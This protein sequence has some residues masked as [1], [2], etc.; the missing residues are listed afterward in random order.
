MTGGTDTWDLAQ[1]PDQTGR[2]ALVTG[3]SPGGLG[4]VTALELARLG[5]HVVLAGRSPERT[6]ATADAIRG[7]VPEAALDTLTVDLADLSSVRRAAAAAARLGRIDLLV[8][9]AGVM[10]VPQARTADGLELQMAT[11][12]FGPF[13]LTGL[14]LPQLSLSPDA[15]VVTVSSLAHKRAPGP[16]LGDPRDASA[17]Y[18]PWPVYGQSKLANLLF[19]FELGRRLRQ[20]GF[21]TRATAA[22]PGLSGTGLFGGVSGVGPLPVAS[23][24]NGAVKAFTQPPSVGARPILMAALA[25]LPDGSYCGPTGP[26]EWRGAPG[27]VAPSRAATDEDSQQALWEISE[28]TVGLSWP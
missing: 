6:E 23:I 14:L 22:H 21:S 24:L 17:R 12:H 2:T 3:T 27:L 18:R 16:P 13:L 1:A 10:A 5:A 25:D 15:R 26:G 20:S 28:D 8:N 9:N 11:N 7:V 4:A 19:T